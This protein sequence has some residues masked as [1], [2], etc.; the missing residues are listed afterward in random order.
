MAIKSQGLTLAPKLK[1]EHLKLTSYS[2]MRVDLAA[3]TYQVLSKPVA[4]LFDYFGDPSTNET[5]RFVLMFDRF[6]DCLN[7]RDL[8][9]WVH[10]L[11]PDLKPY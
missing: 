7:V 6:F 11:K 2:R 9:Q 1:L 4:D 3:Y 8:H 5:K 10:K